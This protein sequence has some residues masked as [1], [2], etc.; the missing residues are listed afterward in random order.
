ML[1]LVA[2]LGV[3]VPALVAGQSASGGSSRDTIPSGAVAL[4]GTPQVRVE[5][6]EQDV[7][8]QLLDSKLAAAEALRID[9]VGGRYFWAS[10]KG[11]PLTLVTSGEFTYL[12]SA[13]PGRY[14]RLRKINDRLSYVEHVDFDQRT[15]TYWG[16]LR[17][18]LAR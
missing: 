5:V 10:R 18:V 8:R 16:E 4:E 17:I 2:V 15:V 12:M 9:I 14:V 13:E 7:R 1:G 3:A 11:E 6:T